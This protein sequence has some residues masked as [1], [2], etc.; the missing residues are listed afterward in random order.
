MSN[1]AKKAHLKLITRP[2]RRGKVVREYDNYEHLERCRNLRRNTSK[3][4]AKPRGIKID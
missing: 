3:F 4:G 2:A 1:K